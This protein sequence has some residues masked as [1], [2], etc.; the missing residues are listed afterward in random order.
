MQAEFLHEKREM[1]LILKPTE[2][3]N[4]SCNFCSSSYLV[5]DK[6]ERLELEK[7]YQFLKRY[8][9]TSV[10]FVVG[11]D[12]LMMTPQYYK[13]LIAHMDEHGYPAKISMTTNLWAF[14]KKPEKWVEIL[15]HPRV[16]VGTSFQYGGGRQISPGVEFTEEIFIDVYNMYKKY[17]PEKE[18]CFLAVVNEENE[19]LAIN[20]VYL[21]K[22]LG[23]QCR[24]VYQSM[25]G[26]SGDVYPISKLYKIM[27][28]IHRLGLTEYE[29]TALSI[30]DKIYGLEGAC[31]VSRNCDSW[32]RSL[33]ADGRY[34]TCGPLNDDLD[35]RN[36]IDFEKEVVRGEAFYT[37]LQT[38]PELQYL[39]EECIS[40]KMFETCNGCRKHTKDLKAQNKVEEHC[41]TMKS[42]MDDL[43]EMSESEEI[44]TLKREIQPTLRESYEVP[45]TR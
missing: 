19:H 28:E 23:I 33:N 21:A 34:F 5:D 3:C 36:E 22:H 32:M 41:T 35:V 14:Y 10:I 18:L 12:P 27:L 20:H 44:L 29:Q 2:A 25:S 15:R 37:P 7:I 45:T 43:F 42:I 24:L 16:E 9:K 30:S 26:K 11:G 6:K 13:D 1:V 40:C 17:V 4:F 38:I 39:K 31:P 8:P